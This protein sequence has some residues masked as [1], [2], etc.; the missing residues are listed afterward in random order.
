MLQPVLGTLVEMFCEH[1]CK[2]LL[3]TKD[4]CFVFCLNHVTQKYIRR[5]KSFL[6]FEDT[7]PL[8]YVAFYDFLS[9][10]T[11]K[12]SSEKYLISSS[13]LPKVEAN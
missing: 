3:R 9:L 10:H 13:I 1:V 2:G 8:H 11:K 7:E 4:T 12:Q 6:L 5:L